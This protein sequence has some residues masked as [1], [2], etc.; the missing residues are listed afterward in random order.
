MF[1]SPSI[2]AFSLTE[3]SPILNRAFIN[4]QT[5]CRYTRYTYIIDIQTS[6]CIHTYPLEVYSLVFTVYV[7]YK[8]DIIPRVA[9]CIPFFGTICCIFQ[10]VSAMPKNREF[11]L[12]MDSVQLILM[13]VRGGKNCIA[14]DAV[15][16]IDSSNPAP[17]LQ[18]D[19]KPG[20]IKEFCLSCHWEPRC[21]PRAA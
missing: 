21:V 2:S 13:R 15:D 16:P 10:I 18:T 4:H 17:I 3:V 9:S 5:A 20:G 14:A 1:L 12:A 7:L 19:I 11:H 6:I 8:S